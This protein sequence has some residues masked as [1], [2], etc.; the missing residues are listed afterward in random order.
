[1]NLIPGGDLTIWGIL[2][3]GLLGVLAYF[4]RTLKKAGVDQQ[5]AKEAKAREEEINRIKRAANVL[6]AGRVSDDPNNRDRR[7]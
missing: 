7:P 4:A 5:K 6:P 3:A 2:A 1:M